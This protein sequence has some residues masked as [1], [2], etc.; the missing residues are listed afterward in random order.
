[1]VV[2]RASLDRSTAVIREVRMSRFMTLPSDVTA[3]PGGAA[4]VVKRQFYG[5]CVNICNFVLHC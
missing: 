5:F 2:Q 1:V 3:R 4:I